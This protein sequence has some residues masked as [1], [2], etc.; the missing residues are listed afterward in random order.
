MEV[1]RIKTVRDWP[2]PQSVRDIQV[3]LGFANFYKRFIK[4]FSRIAAPLTLILQTTD[5]EVLSIQATENKKNQNALA[6]AGGVGGG[7]VDGDIKNLSFV[8]KLA[9]SK[10]PIFTKANS[11]GT[12]FLTI[13]AKETFIYLRKTF[14]KALIF[15]H[16]DLERHIRIETDTLRYAIRGVL[17]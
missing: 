14:T 1:K 6:C 10:K 9:K 15:R 8:I 11:F 12:D 13:G 17:S 3:F 16:F 4:N 5:E 2:E 7:G